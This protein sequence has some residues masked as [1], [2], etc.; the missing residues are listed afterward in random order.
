MES[1]K[2]KMIIELFD[3][4]IAVKY[5]SADKSQDDVYKVAY[6]ADMKRCIGELIY[7]DYAA[8]DGNKVSVKIEM[9]VL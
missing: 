6:N 2:R 1:I 8:L 4:G 5:E 3:N 7:D 9:T